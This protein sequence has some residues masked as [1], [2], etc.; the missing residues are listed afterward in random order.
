[1]SNSEPGA[2][3]VPD[4]RS[5][6]TLSSLQRI[7]VVII[8][9][10]VGLLGV[11]LVQLT[12]QRSSVLQSI[13]DSDS[14]TGNA[15]FTQRESLVMAV[16]YERWM[17]GNETRR[18]VLIR[19][20]LLGRRLDVKDEEGVTNAERA[21]PEY[22]DALEVV[23]GCLAKAPDGFL[24]EA[25]QNLIRVEC[26]E[27][28]DVLVFEARQLAIDISNAGDGRLR[29]II[30]SDR[31][32]RR[33][34]LGWI[35]VTIGMLGVAGVYLGL[36]RVRD[37][38]R[39]RIGIRNDQKTL[40]HSQ[41]ALTIVESELH[42]RVTRENLRRAEDQR[43][44]SAVRMIATDLRRVTSP[45]QIVE[46]LASGLEYATGADLVYVHL[47]ALH[48]PSDLGCLVRNGSLSTVRPSEVGIDRDLS[49][50]MLAQ[51]EKMWLDSEA[52]V[53]RVEEFAVDLSPKM[54]AMI[55][56]L[57]LPKQSFLVPMGEGTS[58]VG[59]VIVGRSGESAWQTYEL[60]ATQNAV[61]HA[62]NAVAALRSLDLV[63]EVRQSQQVVEEMRELDRL[64]NEFISNVNHELRTPL[65]SIIGYLDIIASDDSNLPAETAEFLNIVRR[66]AGRLLELIENL[67][68]VSRSGDPNA[69]TKMESVDF[70]QLVRETVETIR[71][72][73]P[74]S[75]VII[76]TRVDDSLV[77]IMGD[78]LRLEQVV[79]NLVT[80]AVK[81]SRDYSKVVVGVGSSLG[82]G[83]A[84]PEVVLTVA[85]SGIGIP[86]DEIPKLFDRFF[87]ASNA[88][89]A[90]IPGTGLGLPIVKQFVEDHHGTI[91]VES[92]LNVGTTMTVRLPCQPSV[93]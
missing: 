8:V 13:V 59:F 92:T 57:D 64:K 79:V 43:L 89:K 42:S 75:S 56:Q 2:V 49:V 65:T 50:E 90:L 58:I 91:A 88:E 29:E 55:A 45:K 82:E 11:Q 34:Q 68:V 4:E 83:G 70:G 7:A 84:R 81:F 35:L 9:L 16:D 18:T 76:E 27:A 46:R 52:T 62:T 36:S 66:N 37:L 30:D 24:S 10:V 32:D 71:A 86:E 26:G 41:R 67:L 53:L 87:R 44:D 80:N 31:A 23:D 63:K 61:A 72:K 78:R 33:D 1:M 25:D 17:S 39:M 38:R 28:L 51:V 6:F 20:A 15:F 54:L 22:L 93:D 47:F 14:A 69:V 40:E 74:D 73:D 85:D 48:D 21:H 3:E 12:S 19:R 77:P 60:V 5:P